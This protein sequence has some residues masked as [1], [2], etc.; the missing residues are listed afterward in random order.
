[1]IAGALDG[2]TG[3]AKTHT[4]ITVFDLRFERDGA[5]EALL[6]PGW[7]TL[8]FPLEGSVSVGPE[9]QAIPSR[10][11][12]VFDPDGDGP[13][14]LHAKQGARVLVLAGEPLHEPV[15]AYGPFVMNTREEIVQ[16]FRDYQSG[17]MGHL[18]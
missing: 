1:L 12:G 14:Q 8:V 18:L 4:P 17:R 3:P 11:F 6:P 15:V 16:A 10:H 13:V 7:T 5:A 9:R 2:K